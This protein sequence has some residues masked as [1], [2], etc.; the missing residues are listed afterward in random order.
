MRFL[1]L[2]AFFSFFMMVVNVSDVRSE[3]NLIGLNQGANPVVSTINSILPD[4][5]ANIL[6]RRNVIFNHGIEEVNRCNDGNDNNNDPAAA[7]YN[8]VVPITGCIDANNYYGADEKGGNNS[9][10]PKKNRW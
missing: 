1:L 4:D 8:R 10:I 3:D 2:S 9:Y 7:I 6:N 5:A